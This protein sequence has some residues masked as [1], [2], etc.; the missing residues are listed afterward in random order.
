VS[1]RG[2]LYVA[3]HCRGVQ[4]CVMPGHAA[5]GFLKRVHGVFDPPSRAAV[6]GWTDLWGVELTR[7]VSVFPFPLYGVALCVRRHLF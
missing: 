7:W 2:A 4:A 3:R 6:R 1:L 5:V